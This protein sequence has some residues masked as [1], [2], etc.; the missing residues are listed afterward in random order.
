MSSVSIDIAKKVYAGATEAEMLRNMAQ[1]GG[2]R[3]I[4]K[5]KGR[6]PGAYTDY[7][8]IKEPAGWEERAMFDN[9]R[10]VLDPILVYDDGRILNIGA[11]DGGILLA[12]VGTGGKVTSEPRTLESDDI[13]DLVYEVLRKGNG[14]LFSA[15]QVCKEIRKDS[16]EWWQR[17]MQGRPLVDE[18]PAPERGTEIDYSAEVFI[19]HALEQFSQ[20]DRHLVMKG[21]FS[22]FPGRSPDVEPGATDSGTQITVWTWRPAFNKTVR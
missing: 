12:G 17:L 18:Q 15:Y 22:P 3:R 8:Q 20:Q 11:D 7:K 21:T 1:A 9:P 16:P 2:W 6:G 4:Y 5:Y 19:L 14:R 10:A 13:R